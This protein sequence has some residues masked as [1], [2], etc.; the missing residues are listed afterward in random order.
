[1]SVCIAEDYAPWNRNK[2]REELLHE[3]S[4]VR[5]EIC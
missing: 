1:M 2:R 4:F 3:P 5:I